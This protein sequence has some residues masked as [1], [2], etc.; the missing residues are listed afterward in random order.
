MYPRTIASLNRPGDV[1]H[2][3][4]APATHFRVL[5]HVGDTF[6][7]VRVRTAVRHAGEEE[8]L[9]Q[10]THHLPAEAHVVPVVR[11]RI[12]RVPCIVCRAAYPVPWDTAGPGGPRLILCDD[13]NA[14]ADQSVRST[15][16][17]WAY[18]LVPEG[19]NDILVTAETL[20]EGMTALARMATPQHAARVELWAGQRPDAA[21][22]RRVPVM[23]AHAASGIVVLTPLGRAR[24]AGE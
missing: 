22:L 23:L 6:G 18:A 5:N 20:P 14:R 13:C 4:G 21:G 12:L 17:N 3:P 15:P 10:D 9:V 19:R 11:M 16:H 2:F 1:F 8:S 7:M 24:L